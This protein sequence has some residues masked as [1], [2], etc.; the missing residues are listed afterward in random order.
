MALDKALEELLA[1]IEDE[2]DR[3]V[4]RTQLEKHEPLRKGYLAQ[5][6][7][8]RR[9]NS[10]ADQEKADRELHER[11]KTWQATEE[12]RLRGEESELMRR[13]EELQ[14]Q[15]AASAAGKG[16]AAGVDPAALKA[17]VASELGGRGYISKAEMDSVVQAKIAELRTAYAEDL[18]KNILPSAMNWA[19]GMGN[20]ARKFEREFGEDL[21]NQKFAAFMAE[22]NVNDPAKAYEGYV[23]G[24]RAELAIKKAREEGAEEARKELA[25]AR[26]PGNGASPAAEFGPGALMTRRD[27][28]GQAFVAPEGVNPGD[29]TLAI[30]AAK[31]LMAAGKG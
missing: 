21:D 19:V 29:G 12:A 8:S 6:E 16:E 1:V 10:V 31:A 17:L 23:S 11:W 24:R 13:N 25:A 22:H 20:A 4:L 18:T 2:A 30:E 27:K 26:M 15:I 14:S 28:S 3:S 9:M 7:Y 5:S